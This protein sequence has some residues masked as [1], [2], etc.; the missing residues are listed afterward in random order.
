M[1]NNLDSQLVLFPVEGNGSLCKNFFRDPDSRQPSLK[2]AGT[3]GK[4]T[5]TDYP[6]VGPGHSETAAAA[7]GKPDTR[8]GPCQVV[9]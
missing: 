3:K 9:G 1:F 8:Q 4:C 5:A 2:T 6:V 7:V